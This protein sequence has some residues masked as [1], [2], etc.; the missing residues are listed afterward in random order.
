MRSFIDDE[1][2]A[3]R[4]SPTTPLA[5]PYCIQGYAAS[6]SGLPAPVPK[7]SGG[8]PSADAI[9]LA[10]DHLSVNLGKQIL[11]LVPGYVSTEVRPPAPLA[12][13]MVRISACA[14]VHTS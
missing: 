11:A 13:R 3:I 10:I 8:R 2:F 14:L 7:H 4:N 1:V 12:R 5:A 6:G 9:S